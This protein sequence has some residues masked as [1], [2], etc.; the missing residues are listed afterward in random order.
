[1]EPITST[2]RV[3]RPTAFA[4]VLT[5]LILMISGCDQIEASQILSRAGLVETV[6]DP[7]EADLAMID[8]DMQS[9][10]PDGAMRIYY[11]FVDRSGRVQFVERI[12][13][14]PVAWRAQV[15]FVE[16]NQP[17]P[18]TPLAAR[19]SWQVSSTRTA[20][21]LAG[22]AAA[23][24]T[25]TGRRT[26]RQDVILYYASWCGYCKQAKAH[27]DREG[28]DYD[29]RNV[30]NAEIKNELKQKT[31]RT[32]IPVLDFSGEILRGYSADQYSQ[33]IRTIRS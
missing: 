16:M 26:Q 28:V 23:S 3:E 33:V 21:I 17:P 8:P 31:G 19:R 18:L 32:G 22:N 25:P 10:G 13:D 7:S 9:V 1:M 2:K 15:G 6:N 14:V 12:T 4:A 5:L 11:Q 29:L 24:P 27:L 30:D 20:Q